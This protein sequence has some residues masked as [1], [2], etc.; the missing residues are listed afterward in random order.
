VFA[1]AGYMHWKNSLKQGQLKANET[2]F[3]LAVDEV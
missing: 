2:H 1:R 3:D